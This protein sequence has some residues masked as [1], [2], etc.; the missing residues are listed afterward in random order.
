MPNLRRKISMK[1]RV[2]LDRSFLWKPI[3]NK[4]PCNY[5]GFCVCKSKTGIIIP[6]RRRFPLSLD[7]V[8]LRF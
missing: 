2:E 5:K 3:E 7:L 1:I 4:S 6:L 8:P